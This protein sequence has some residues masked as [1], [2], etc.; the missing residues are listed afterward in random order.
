MNPVTPH[1]ITPQ[2]DVPRS[3][4]RPEYVGRPA[5]KRYTGSHVQ[6]AEVIEKMVGTFRGLYG[7]TP[8]EITADEYA[9][10]EKLVTD[11]FGT[12]EWLQRVP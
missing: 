5:P 3:I 9:R 7:L 10:A 12:D 11:K 1:T 6:P 8:S 2:R 4:P